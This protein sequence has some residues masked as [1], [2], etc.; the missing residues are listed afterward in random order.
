M[1]F[2]DDFGR[3]AGAPGRA[4]PTCNLCR[5]SDRT[6]GG[7]LS[8]C[9]FKPPTLFR[10]HTAYI[11]STHIRSHWL[12][13]LLSQAMVVP[14]LIGDPVVILHPSCLTFTALVHNKLCSMRTRV[15]MC[16]CM[17]YISVCARKTH[18]IGKK[19]EDTQTCQITAR[20]AC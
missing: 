3:R 16:L 12:L 2:G 17:C 14:F 18:N 8:C 1:L 7:V 6:L 10:E 15:H 11:P 5:M 4:G 19:A 13:A 20:A 9:C